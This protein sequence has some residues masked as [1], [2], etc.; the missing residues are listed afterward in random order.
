MGSSTWWRTWGT[1]VTPEHARILRRHAEKVVLCF[2]A[3]QA[4]QNASLRGIDVLRQAGCSVRI[5]EIP[6]G[7]DPDQYIRENVGKPFCMK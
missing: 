7:K 4:G 1:A 6:Q 3:D 2:D 5:A